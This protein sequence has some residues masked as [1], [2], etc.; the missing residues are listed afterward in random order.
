MSK[1]IYEGDF[2]FFDPSPLVRKGLQTLIDPAYTRTFNFQHLKEI[3]VA[4]D[5]N[6]KQTVIMELY[7]YS[8]NLYDVIQFILTAR[9][10]WPE[11]AFVI[12]TDI[13]HPGILAILA[14]EPHLSLVSK[15][16]ALDCLPS[17]ITAARDMQGY[18]SPSIQSQLPFGEPIQPLSHSE[19]RILA[20]MTSGADP[21]RIAQVTQ[22]SYKTVST[23][24][25]NIMRKLQLNQ[26][27][28]MR[29]ILVFRTRYHSL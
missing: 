12:F 24:K 5:S 1:A 19:W 16:D 10:F 27:D 14:M 13:T 2:I 22:R 21:Q 25:L 8:E 28:F 3:G 20:L 18:H 23:H 26:A 15:R 6:E 4:L 17:A 7:S 9:V 11:T 29:L